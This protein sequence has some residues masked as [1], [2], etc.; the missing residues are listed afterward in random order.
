MALEFNWLALGG[1]HLAVALLL[2]YLLKRLFLLAVPVLNLLVLTAKVAPTGRRPG[3]R[4]S[5]SY[6][7]RLFAL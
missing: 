7:P 2:S 5:V 1:T 4:F 6:R 3:R